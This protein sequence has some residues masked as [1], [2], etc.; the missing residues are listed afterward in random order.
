MLHVVRDVAVVV[1]CAAGAIWVLGGAL[2][3]RNRARGR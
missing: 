3:L 1:V 2:W